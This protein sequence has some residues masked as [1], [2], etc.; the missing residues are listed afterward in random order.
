ME[1]E[2]V[3]DNP[4]DEPVETVEETTEEVTEQASEVT[5]EVEETTEDTE[6]EQTA[7]EESEAEESQETEVEEESSQSEAEAED[8]TRP[9]EDASH[10]EWAKWRREQ[11]ERKLAEETARQQA[12]NKY[13]NEADN[14][15]DRRLREIEVNQANANQRIY[16]DIVERN[17][18]DILADVT[19]MESDPDT[20]IFN[21]KNKDT[22]NE[23]QFARMQASYEA[24]HLRTNPNRP[25][26]IVEVK[27][28]F[29]KFAKEWASDLKQDMKIAEAR[30]TKT[31][32]RNLSKSEP[33][34][35]SVSK[36]PKQSDPLEDL[37]DSDD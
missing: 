28:S 10:A 23:R 32:S 11:R 6:A 8:D 26:D 3:F 18:R 2:D 13:L 21:P 24:M 27:E 35:N 9:A 25:E 22:F 14:D 36:P 1:N 19:R 34:S 37:W 33:A 12:L 5:T 20:Q 31:A 17:A 29:Y 16:D 30:A 4:F 7:T 15:E